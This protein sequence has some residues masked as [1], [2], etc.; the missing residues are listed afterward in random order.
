MRVLILEGAASRGCLAAA[1]SLARAGWEVGVG[2]AP[3]HSLAAR[4]NAVRHRVLLPPLQAGLDGYVEAIRHAVRNHGFDAV[5]GAG[6]AEALALAERRNDIPAVV[7]HPEPAALLAAMDKWRLH[8][9]A[10]AAGLASPDTCEDPRSRAVRAWLGDGPVVV[11]PRLHWDPRRP[12]SE[13]RVDAGLARSADDLRR[14]TETVEAAGGTA[15]AQRF[16]SGHLMAYTTVRHA[17]GSVAH[18]QQ[19]ALHT[20]PEPVGATARA[21]TIPI[22]TSLAASADRLLSDLGVTGLAQLQFLVGDDGRPHLIDLN[23][24]YYG[25]MQLAIAAGVDVPV[26]WAEQV[27]GSLPDA[28][29]PRTARPGVH[30]QWLEGD[31]RRSVA[32]G[33]AGRV[34][35]SLLHAGRAHHSIWSHR[36]PRPA[37][38]HVAELVRRARRRIGAQ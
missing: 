34:A 3:G 21:V 25:S 36:D 4:S 15:I 5:V 7:P 8:K 23:A 19:R 27:H 35:G 38:S 30:Y 2:G 12:G 6:D 28:R 11:K 20:W 26:L 1:R 14:L 10:A 37:V 32:L 18:V 24:R 17:A 22:E 33:G 31:L 9:S 16:L 13:L 29:P